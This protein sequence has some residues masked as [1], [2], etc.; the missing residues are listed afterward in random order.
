MKEWFLFIVIFFLIGNSSAIKAQKRKYL[1]IRERPLVWFDLDCATKTAY[2]KL[3]LDRLVKP[4]MKQV[5]SDMGKWGDRAFAFD[6]NGDGDKE[7]FV[8]LDCSGLGNCNWGIFSTKPARWLGIINGEHIWV[9][10]R[11]GNWSRLTVASHMNVSESLLRTYRF[12]NGKYR[13]FGSDY[14][15][16]AYKGNEVENL[17]TVKPTCDRHRIRQKD[18]K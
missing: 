15:E 12:T 8:L 17:Y 5:D 2:S 7:V 13:R 10:R 1:R 9:H 6:L 4:Y 11:N 3:K 18:R 16:S 14:L